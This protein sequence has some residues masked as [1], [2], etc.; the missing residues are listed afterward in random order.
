MLLSIIII[1][2]TING[3]HTAADSPGSPGLACDDGERMVHKENKDKMV[4]EHLPVIKD[5]LEIPYL[6]HAPLKE[7]KGKLDFKRREKRS[8]T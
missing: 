5:Y 3:V 7:N 4:F 6:F 2:I 1:I 8:R